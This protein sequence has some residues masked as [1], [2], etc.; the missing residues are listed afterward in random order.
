[1]P[2]MS[3]SRTRPRWSGPRATGGTTSSRAFHNEHRVRNGFARVGDPVEV[4]TVRAEAVGQP[5]ARWDDLPPLRPSGEP[6]R[7]ERAVVTATGDATSTV[8]DATVWWRPALPTGAEVIGPAVIEGEES[9]TWLGPGERAQCP[10]RRGNRG[11]MVTLSPFALEVARN[12]LS[13]VADEMGLVLRRTAASPNIKERADCSAAVFDAAGEMLAQAEH[14]PVHLGSMPASVEAVIRRFGD[15]VEPG[16]QYAVNDPYEGGTHLNDLTLVR[17]V[18]LADA[19]VGWVANRAHHADVGG[20]A[21]GSM[22]AHAVTVEQ[23]GC[24]VAPMAAVR[25][26][27]WLDDFREPFLSATRTPAERLGDLSAQLGANE[28]GAERLL[29]LAGPD[30]A[31]FAGMAAEV[32][33]Y[34]ERRMRAALGDLACG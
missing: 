7:G 19:L 9:T 24:R 27:D 3:V 33:D 30:G 25:S 4:V 22:P 13:A 10:P 15:E 23:E 12:Q 21:P 14:I 2:G 5:A 32:L 34:G 11:G 29:R 6:A 18:H 8:V 31:G 26:G 20:E 16:V 17:P 1:M 28:V